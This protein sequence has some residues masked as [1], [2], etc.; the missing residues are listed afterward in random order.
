MAGRKIPMIADLDAMLA[1][2]PEEFYRE[3]APWWKGPVKDL[4][5][6]KAQH[7]P[8]STDALLKMIWGRLELARS[9]E[10]FYGWAGGLM[11]PMSDT[12]K[13]WLLRATMIQRFGKEW[14][15]GEWR[16]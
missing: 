9:D 5:D 7:W 8:P 6:G 10:G 4:L 15:E 14:R 16:K 3:Y 12:L 2:L 13:E 11:V 1:A